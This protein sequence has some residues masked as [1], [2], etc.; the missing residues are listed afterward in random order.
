MRI[1]V[2]V[3]VRAWAGIPGS[4]CLFVFHQRGWRERVTITF[5]SERCSVA[6]RSVYGGRCLAGRRPA[7]RVDGSA[8]RPLTQGVTGQHREVPPGGFPGRGLW[9]ASSPTGWGLKEATGT[10]LGELQREEALGGKGCCEHRLQRCGARVEP[11]MPALRGQ[12]NRDRGPWGGPDSAAAAS[13]HQ[14][15]QSLSQSVLRTAASAILR[16]TNVTLLLTHQLKTW[17]EMARVPGF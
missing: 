16:K 13:C 5:V 15:P 14:P 3:Y 1:R 7:D 11:G 4:V 9:L 2:S 12:T 8:L 17:S 6:G 10:Q